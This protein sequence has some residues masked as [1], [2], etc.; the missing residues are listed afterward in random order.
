METKYSYLFLA[1]NTDIYH[2]RLR[3]SIARALHRPFITKISSVA[4]TSQ[5]DVLYWVVGGELYE[6]NVSR[7]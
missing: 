5:L 4:F 1:S 7:I 2:Y 3:Y 6:K